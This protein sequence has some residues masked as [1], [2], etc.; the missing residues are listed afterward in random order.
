MPPGSPQRLGAASVR[1]GSLCLVL[2]LA[3]LAM[4]AL[5]G[6]ARAGAPGGPG[7]AGQQ[8][9]ASEAGL[10]GAGVSGDRGVDVGVDVHW[11]APFLDHS[12]FGGEAAGLVLGGLLR[13][14]VVR[15]GQLHIGLLQDR[16]EDQLLAPP[17]SGAEAAAAAA[18]GGGGSGPP[19]GRSGIADPSGGVGDDREERAAHHQLLALHSRPASPAIVVRVCHN[20][21]PY[22][23][24]P[25]PRWASCE[26][27]PPPGHPVRWAVARAM[28]ETDRIPAS[29]VT[30]LN[31]MDEVWVPAPASARVLRDSGVRVPLTELPPAVDAAGELDPDAVVPL[32][33]PP[34]GCVQ[35]FGPPGRPPARPY[36]FVSVFK[37][38]A[39]KGHDVL[40]PAF[41][42]QFGPRAEGATGAAGAAAGAA[43][44]GGAAAAGADQELH[45]EEDAGAAAEWGEGGAAGGAE[46][47]IVT[48]PF[49]QPQPQP[50]PQSGQSIADAVGAWAQAATGPQGGG[51]LD[52]R[53]APR[54]YLLSGHLPRQQY[55]RLL[56]A[57]D[58]FVLPTRGEGWGL[59]IIEAMALG[60]PVI[61]T[62]WSGPTAYLD[63]LVGYPLSYQLSPVPP[64]EPWWFQG[65]NWAE[66][67]EHHLRRLLAH[68]SGSA[69]GRREAAARG[70][71]ARRRV[72]QHYSFSAAAERL[73]RE[74]NLIVAA[75][76]GPQG[77]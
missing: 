18:A 2:V 5:M 7:G 30:A 60:L 58:A 3:A 6:G 50:Q 65:S 37:W 61:A 33:L 57:A 63:E 62:N 47:Y 21:P 53:R 51:R 35:V 45:G 31:S 23:G 55:V 14:G 52:R 71:A 72:L 59:P 68:V 20:L 54:V 66:P 9:N 32:Q 42:R 25:A 67:S 13:G 70:A 34:P 24:R 27:C 76:G 26:P 41:L 46:L 69:E 74:L 36:V 73:R 8:G 44:A 39:R 40:I 11:F 22:L 19:A 16:C 4:G 56:A 43:G 1:A 49:L 10:A 75:T 38:E 15:P 48:K 28:A 64:S 77:P 29:F 12:S 17:A